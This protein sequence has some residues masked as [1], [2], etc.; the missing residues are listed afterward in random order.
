MH[1]TYSYTYLILEGPW[2]IVIEI[3]EVTQLVARSISR[4]LG[5]R[6][7]SAVKPNCSHHIGCVLSVQDGRSFH[8][9]LL[10][11]KVC[12]SFVCDPSAFP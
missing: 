3:H 9:G 7:I 2:R 12:K 10:R 8:R 6:F 11:V 4:R 5:S 1:G